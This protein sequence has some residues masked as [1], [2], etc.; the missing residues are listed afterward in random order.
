MQD[1]KPLDDS[2]LVECHDNMRSPI[3]KAESVETSFRS[4]EKPYKRSHKQSSNDNES[5]ISFSTQ[6]SNAANPIW[7]N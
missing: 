5:V 2:F 4:A 1:P 7:H 6:N 3:K